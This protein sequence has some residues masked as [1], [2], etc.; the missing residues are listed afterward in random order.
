ME[1]LTDPSKLGGGIAVAFVATV[2]GLSLANIVYFPIAG[3]LKLRH[4]SHMIAKE[5]ILSGVIAI[6]E[7]ENPRL[8]EDKLKSFLNQGDKKPMANE[9]PDRQTRVA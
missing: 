3:K 1:N 5:I 9:A 4:R 6:L 2:Y 8:I 7:V